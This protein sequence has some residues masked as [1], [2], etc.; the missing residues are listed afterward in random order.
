VAEEVSVVSEQA[1]AW[2]SEGLTAVSESARPRLDP[3]L[4]CRRM[5]PDLLR[6][7]RRTRPTSDY[8]RA[9][10]PD[11]RMPSL[12]APPRTRR[13]VLIAPRRESAHK[14]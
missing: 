8:R 12:R 2:V 3:F 9:P 6:A 4:G 13:V 11:Y 14:A 1:R 10:H 5:R 7:Y